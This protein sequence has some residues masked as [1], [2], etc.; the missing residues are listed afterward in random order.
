MLDPSSR[1]V[2]CMDFLLVASMDIS[3]GN[4]H[5]FDKLLGVVYV[6]TRIYITSNYNY[7]CSRLPRLTMLQILLS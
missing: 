2:V 6:I 7:Y 3:L 1:A 4:I 5:S